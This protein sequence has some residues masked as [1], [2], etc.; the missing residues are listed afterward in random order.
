[1][2]TD[3]TIQ[4]H[5]GYNGPLRE[6]LAEPVRE[7][8]GLIQVRTVESAR[9]VMWVHVDDYCEALHQAKKEN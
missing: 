1:M 4:L 9:L 2:P 7:E 6:F 5:D 8:P 3:L